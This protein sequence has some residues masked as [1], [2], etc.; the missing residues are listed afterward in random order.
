MGSTVLPFINHLITLFSSER[1]RTILLSYMAACVQYEGVK[2]QWAPL[3]HGPQGN[4]KTFLSRCVAVAIGRDNS[5]CP[6]LY[7]VQS[8]FNAWIAGISFVHVE[9]CFPLINTTIFFE[10]LKAM[11]AGGPNYGI[12]TLGA[13]SRRYG[14]KANFILNS[15]R[16]LPAIF[17]NDNR[18]FAIFKTERK[19]P[20]HKHLS[21]LYQW[22]D[23]G[24]YR[25]VTE[26]L[27][28]YSIPEEFNPTKSCFCAPKTSTS[29]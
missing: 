17:I 15:S 28:E 20:S 3:I 8:L 14:L 4:G 9:E 21:E 6:P 29:L 16:R 26:A 7:Q 13:E 19:I 25:C 12:H 18:R 27:Q 10:K 11:I 5:Y 22:A 24:G 1:D 23:N 2:F